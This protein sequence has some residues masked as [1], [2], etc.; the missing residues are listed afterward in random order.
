MTDPFSPRVWMRGVQQRWARLSGRWRSLG[1]ASRAALAAAVLV[2]AAT[3]YVGY[4]EHQRRALPRMVSTLVYDAS[5][6]LQDALRN[7][8][9]GGETLRAAR[10]DEHYAAVNAHLLKL[11]AVDASAFEDFGHAADDFLLTT[12]EILRRCA[13]D[14]RYRI[15]VSESLATLRAHMRSD[16]RTGSWVTEAVQK[17]ARLEV[18]YREYRLTAQTLA[19]LLAQYPAS[20]SRLAAYVDDALLADANHALAA[21][22][23]S[24]QALSAITA[25]V[26]RVRQLGGY[27]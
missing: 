22:A 20:R 8:T 6:R 15:N 9:G 27:R 4:S 26:E 24:L 11:R 18:D 7:E 5:L 14:R 2:I 10:L 21:R 25:E 12:R 19:D 3:V 13:V 23:Q 16:T 17:K 1:S